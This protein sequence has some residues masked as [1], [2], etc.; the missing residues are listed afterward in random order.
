MSS[1]LLIHRNSN[2]LNNFAGKQKNDK[3]ENEL[4]YL[5]CLINEGK[6]ILFLVKNL[7]F[8]QGHLIKRV[9]CINPLNYMT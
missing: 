8:N 6:L 7:G 5:N 4:T 2:F 1:P 9:K 3:R